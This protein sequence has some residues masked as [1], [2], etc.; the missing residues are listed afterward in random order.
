MNKTKLFTVFD[1][2]TK[3]LRPLRSL[4]NFLVSAGGLP[5][6][7]KED[8]SACLSIVSDNASKA[9]SQQETISHE[10]TQLAIVS[11]CVVGG[12]LCMAT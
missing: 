9:I 2:Q 4:S 11:N 5:T 10:V 1:N 6:H 7:S 3:Q 12:S 8:L